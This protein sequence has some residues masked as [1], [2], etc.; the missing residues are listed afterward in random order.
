MQTTLSSAETFNP[1]DWW[2]YKELKNEPNPDYYPI[3]VCEYAEHRFL[4][5]LLMLEKIS[6]KRKN[7]KN[8]FVV[9]TNIFSYDGQRELVAT[10]IQKQLLST[11]VG[12]K[13]L[14]YRFTEE[15]YLILTGK[16]SG[17]ICVPSPYFKKKKK[18]KAYSVQA[19]RPIHNHEKILEKI[20]IEIQSL[21]KN[22][23]EYHGH[24]IEL[25]ELTSELIKTHGYIHA[26]IHCLEQL[27][28]EHNSE[29]IIYNS[30][31]HE[32]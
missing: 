25:L 10:G 30:T 7:F 9:P 8:S 28:F 2:A 3:P 15:S 5:F 1:Q 18:N 4:A 16:L 20:K 12:K 22:K 6:K 26:I 19:Y 23:S 31:Q 11:G 14:I 24:K 32:K 27:N 13:R 29:R 17:S 21:Y